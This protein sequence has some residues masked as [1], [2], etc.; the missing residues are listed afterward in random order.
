MS[1]EQYLSD[2]KCMMKN[3]GFQFII[4]RADC[5]ERQNTD[6]PEDQPLSENMDLAR[7]I[8]SGCWFGGD[9]FRWFFPSIE[10]ESKVNLLSPNH[11]YHGNMESKEECHYFLIITTSKE[12]VVF[13]TYGGVLQLIIV[14]H[15]LDYANQLIGETRNNDIEAMET[16]FGVSADYKKNEVYSLELTSTT[17]TFPSK[18][19]ILAKI[20]LLISKAWTKEDARAIEELRSHI[21]DKCV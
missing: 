13:N 14:T 5:F 4:Y 11:I 19:D 15:E 10:P 17:D 20:D 18:A 16:L 9:F 1:W 2:F 12:A 7:E 8:Y 3:I 21:D 6:I